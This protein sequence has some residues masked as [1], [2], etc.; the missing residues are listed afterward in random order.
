MQKEQQVACQLFV[1]KEMVQGNGT[2]GHEI[3]FTLCVF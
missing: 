3:P 2:L 1:I